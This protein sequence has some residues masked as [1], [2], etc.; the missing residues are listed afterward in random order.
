M[1]GLSWFLYL[2]DVVGNVSIMFIIFAVILFF[3]SGIGIVVGKLVPW[4]Y[5]LA[6]DEVEAKKS[7]E[8]FGKIGVRGFIIAL[9]LSTTAALIPQKTTMYMMAAS[10]MG[11]MIVQTETGKEI[12][13]ELKSTVIDQLRELRSKDSSTVS[14]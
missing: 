4:D 10:E 3:V 11:E 13:G 1:N 6:T 14:K 9:V 8:N 12:F 2:A 5:R 7:R